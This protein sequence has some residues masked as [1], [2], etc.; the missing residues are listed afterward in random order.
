[1]E[2][3]GPFSKALRNLK[4][5][6]GDLRARLGTRADVLLVL[7]GREEPLVSELIEILELEEDSFEIAN[8]REAAI[9]AIWAKSYR[10][11]Y[12]S[13]C[14]ICSD[15]QP[16]PDMYELLGSNEGRLDVWLASGLEIAKYAA[17]K[18]MPVVVGDEGQKSKPAYE[19]LG[20]VV[21]NKVTQDAWQHYKKIKEAMGD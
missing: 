20:A 9:E 4:E 10:C 5:V 1:M 12:L 7:T 15:G 14:A 8:G 2:R 19:S 21:L 6:K 17:K 3:D 13:D 18:R 16:D 11:V